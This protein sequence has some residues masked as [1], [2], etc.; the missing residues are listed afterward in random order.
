MASEAVLHA[1]ETN[2][3]INIQTVSD[4]LTI[5]QSTVVHHLHD[6]SSNHANLRWKKIKVALCIFC[7]RERPGIEPGTD[8]IWKRKRVSILFQLFIQLGLLIGSGIMLLSSWMWINGQS[9]S[10]VEMNFGRSWRRQF[11]QVE[12]QTNKQTDLQTDRGTKWRKKEEEKK[13]KN[14]EARSWMRWSK[15]VTKRKSGRRKRMEKNIFFLLYIYQWHWQKHLKLSSE[16]Y[17]TL[18]KHGKNKCLVYC[19]LNKGIGLMSRVFAS[20]PGDQGSIPGW[21]IPKT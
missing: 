8:D 6:W 18:L 5:S 13:Q 12:R 7:Q 20:G 3:A 9:S 11:A 4:K 21:V 15:K 10:W 16:L 1:I 14:E 17:L 2:L 19:W